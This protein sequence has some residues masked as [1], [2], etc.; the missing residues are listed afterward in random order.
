MSVDFS[1]LADVQ[2]SL[3]TGSLSCR[4]LV[5]LYLGRITEQSHLNAFVEVYGTEARKEAAR[6]DAA[7]QAGKAGRLAGLVLGVKDVICH[8]G[9]QLHAS[10]R[11]LDPF[12][13]QFTATALQRLLDEDAIVIGRLSC[14]EFAM[15]SS[16]EHAASGPVRN[17]LDPNRVPGGSSGGSAAAVAAGLCHAA[18]GSDTGGSVRQPAAFCGVVGT[19]PTYGRISR[20]IDC[21]CFEL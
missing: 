17:P 16:N 3:S 11:M 2:R 7:F 12:E 6:V 19:K 4:D 15:G 1:S 10:S 5:E 14:D 21:L 20:W 13:A 8:A 9:H 18:L